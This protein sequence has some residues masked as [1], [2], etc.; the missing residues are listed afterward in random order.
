MAIINQTTTELQIKIVYY[1]PAMSGKTT[2]MVKLHEALET[3]AGDKGKLISLSTS[4]DR[5]LFFDFFPMEPRSVKGFRTRFQ[6]Y[7]VPGPV[8]YNTT[9]Q[10]VLRGVDGV[11]FVADSAKEKMA[12]NLKSFQNLMENLT[13]LTL[14]L[15]DVPYVLQYNKRDLSNATPLEQMEALLNNRDFKVP[16]FPGIA[17]KCSGVL[18]PLNQLK[19]ML[20]HKFGETLQ[21]NSM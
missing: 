2:N 15:N 5:T 7:A 17:T 9:L 14:N 19:Q 13:S 20:L 12:A 4:S 11:V 16:S 1:G 8:T 3:G 21:L 18:E 10:L 6:L